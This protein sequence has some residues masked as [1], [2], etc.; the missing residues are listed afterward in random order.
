MTQKV[1]L[2]TGKYGKKQ[3]SIIKAMWPW[4]LQLPFALNHVHNDLN[5]GLYLTA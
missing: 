3:Y 2:Y 4:P 1:D 5:I